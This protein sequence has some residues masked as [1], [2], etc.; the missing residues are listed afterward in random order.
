MD[1]TCTEMVW[2]QVCFMWGGLLCSGNVQYFMCIK[3]ELVIPWRSCTAEAL[4]AAPGEGANVPRAGSQHLGRAGG[5]APVSG[6]AAGQQ[7]HPA[8]GCWE[9]GHGRNA[10][11]VAQHLGFP[12]GFS[13]KN[14]SLQVFGDVVFRKAWFCLW[15]LKCTSVLISGGKCTLISEVAHKQGIL[16]NNP[17]GKHFWHLCVCPY[18]WS[19]CL[20]P[21]CI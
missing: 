11:G 19:N 12:P 18:F 15:N 20:L 2:G 1:F 8:P 3:H 9:N 10:P 17:T 16:I 4:R 7:L 13:G 5:C 14:N 6:W 21:E